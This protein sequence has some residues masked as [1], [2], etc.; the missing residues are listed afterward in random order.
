VRSIGLKFSIYLGRLSLLALVYFYIL[1]LWLMGVMQYPWK[2]YLFLLWWIMLAFS[3][4]LVW[5]LLSFYHLF[6]V[7]V[8]ML[9]TRW[10]V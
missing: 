5:F 4:E 6:Q 7:K 1:M 2:V 8:I 3:L 9:G 10:E